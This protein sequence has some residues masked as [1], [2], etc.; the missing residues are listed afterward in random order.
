MSKHTTSLEI[1][2]E[3]SRGRSRPGLAPADLAEARRTD[4]PALPVAGGRKPVLKDEAAPAPA[5][6]RPLRTVL[7]AGAGLA[8]LAGA[9]ISAWQYWT[10][11][12]SRC[13]PTDAPMS[14]TTP[15]SHQR[16]R[17]HRRC[18]DRRQ[19]AVKA[20]QALARIDDRDFQVAL[21]Q[22]NAESPP[23]PG[24]R[25]PSKQASLDN[26]Q[27]VIDTARATS[28]SARPT[29]P[30]RAGR[31]ALRGA[32]AT[33]SAACRTPNRVARIARPAP[34]SPATRRPDHRRSGRSTSSR[35]ISSRPR[36]RWRMTRP[37]QRKRS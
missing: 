33:A 35:P 28:T 21:D 19:S 31:Q 37:A 15:R 17:L 14:A 27:S 18:A 22:A 7:L 6:R 5:P 23:P 13:R 3:N 4:A 10:V 30:L 26:Q 25:S 2:R 8:I 34:A 12:A 24:G 16:F 9:A 11:G 29:R 36:R 20:G 1:E 32:G